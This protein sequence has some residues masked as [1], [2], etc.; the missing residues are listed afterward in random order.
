MRINE[1][2]NNI[3]YVTSIAYK[4]DNSSDFIPL[5]AS[6]DIG[7]TYLKFPQFAIFIDGVKGLA[8]LLLFIV[9]AYRFSIIN[10]IFSQ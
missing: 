4:C 2:F 8:Y 7:K 6:R 3:V 1:G 9:L 5:L 10:G